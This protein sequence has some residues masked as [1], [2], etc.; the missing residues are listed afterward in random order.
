MQ[1]IMGS[2]TKEIYFSTLR[3]AIFYP[4]VQL[5]AVKRF[6]SHYFCRGVSA[7]QRQDLLYEDYILFFYEERFVLLVGALSL[8]QSRLHTRSLIVTFGPEI[9]IQRK[10]GP[11]SM[12]AC[13]LFG[14]GSNATLFPQIQRTYAVRS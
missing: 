14:F 1:I 10:K 7:L 2:C 11:Y 3:T 4:K 12:I 8:R 5:T 9:C 6:Q 13:S